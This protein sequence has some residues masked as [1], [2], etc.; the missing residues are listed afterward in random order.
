MH[1][2][3]TICKSLGPIAGITISP[4]DTLLLQPTN[5]LPDTPLHPRVTIYFIST[6]PQ[7]ILAK[8]LPLM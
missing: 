2:L 4:Q 6:L 5:L 1:A 7:Q 3:F 8:D